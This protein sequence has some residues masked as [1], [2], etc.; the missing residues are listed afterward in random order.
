[1]LSSVFNLEI[2]ENRT[3]RNRTFLSILLF[4]LKIALWGH[5]N[6]MLQFCFKQSLEKRKESSAYSLGLALSRE[7]EEDED[8]GQM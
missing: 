2:I 3:T 6:S 1:M 5:Q 4:T 7:E 8:Q